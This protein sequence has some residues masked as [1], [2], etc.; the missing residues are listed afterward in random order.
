MNVYRSSKRL[1]IHLWRL[2]KATI[3][4]AILR[5]KKFHRITITLAQYRSLKANKDFINSIQLARIVNSI[6]SAHRMILRIPDNGDLANTRDR[7]E[8]EYF[9]SSVVFEALAFLL[10]LSEDL[11][12]LASW[13]AYERLITE[14]NKERYDKSSYFRTVLEPIR[15]E[16]VFHFEAV[17]VLE[18]LEILDPKGRINLLISRTRLNKDMVFPLV[19][20]LVMNYAISR[21]KSNKPG[22]QKYDDWRRYVH[23]T[24]VKVTQIANA[25]ILEI[26]PRLAEKTRER[27]DR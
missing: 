17:A 5:W 22:S 16:V 14:L 18:A 10:R 2:Y 13:K 27:L 12:H 25:C 4:A 6:G 11:K 8:Y 3:G 1:R 19:T 21:D 20:D 9:Y 7:L 15:N 24:A 23:E 26:W